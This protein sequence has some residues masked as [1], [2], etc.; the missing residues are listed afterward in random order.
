MS[1]FLQVKTIPQDNGIG[2]AEGRPAMAR[3]MDASSQLKGLRGDV[4]QYVAQATPQFDA[5][6]AEKG[7]FWMETN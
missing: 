6:I 1:K 7:H 5:E 4:L 3:G 2:S